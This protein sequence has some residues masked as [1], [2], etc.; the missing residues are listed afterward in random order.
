[1]IAVGVPAG[2]AARSVRVTARQE[3]S[4]T[5]DGQG[6]AYRGAVLERDTAEGD[7]PHLFVVRRRVIVGVHVDA[8][9]PVLPGLLGDVTDQCSADA[10]AHEGGVDEQILQRQPVGGVGDRG[11]PDDLAVDRRGTGPALLDGVG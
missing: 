6:H 11:E 8:V 9:Q 5:T 4:L 10:L 7:E 1:V 2:C 3:A